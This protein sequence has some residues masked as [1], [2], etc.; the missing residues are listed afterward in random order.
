MTNKSTNG[1]VHRLIRPDSNQSRDY[2]SGCKS[3]LG[4]QFPES[5]LL[6]ANHF[7]LVDQSS[8][9]LGGA[10]LVAQPGFRSLDGIPD[11]NRNRALETVGDVRAIAEI[12]GV[13]LD[14]CLTSPYLTFYFW[15]QIID[16]RL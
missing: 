13:W 9:V 7:V 4:L 5:Y 12:N 10:L 2:L 8:K 6:R 11:A 16:W 15:C 1:Q 3:F 14:C